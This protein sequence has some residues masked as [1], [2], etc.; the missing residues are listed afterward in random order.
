[1]EYSGNMGHAEQAEVLKKVLDLEVISTNM[2][3]ELQKLTREQFRAAPQKPE[4]P[5]KKGIEPLPYPV[6]KSEMKFSSYISSFSTKDKIIF[7]VLMLIA[8]VN[9]YYLWKKYSEFADLKKNDI[10]RIKNSA[11]YKAECEKIDKKNSENQASSDAEYKKL[12]DEYQKKLKEYEDVILPQY[13]RDFDLWSQNH[14]KD[15]EQ[16][17]SALDEA[18]SELID[19]YD[20]TKILPIQYRKIDT[21]RFIYEMVST[22]DYDVKQAIDKYDQMLQRQ[23]D[24][25]R[26]REQQIANENQEIANQ[27]A[28]EQNE[29]VAEQNKIAQ[30]ARRDANIAS[31]VGAVQRHNTNKYLRG[32]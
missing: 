31:V 29:L 18:R 28:A 8:V 1:M 12:L 22:S 23:L 3:S 17:Q 20:K 24:T 27:I 21:I 25:E 11:E 30:K 16:K 14:K 13:K 7:I 4:K 2:Q 32:K 26:L 15:I 10:E 9:V 6:P 19:I 5:E